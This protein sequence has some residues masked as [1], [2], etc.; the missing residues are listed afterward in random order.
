MPVSAAVDGGHGGPLQ[1]R[2]FTPTPASPL[3]GEGVRG[4]NT[5]KDGEFFSLNYSP[6]LAQKHFCQK[7]FDKK[8]RGYMI[9]R[10]GPPA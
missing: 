5:F 6:G 7:I 2:S 3:K 10:L 8:I 1:R 4:F 9:V